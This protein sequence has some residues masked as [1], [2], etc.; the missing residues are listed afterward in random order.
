MINSNRK[1]KTLLTVLSIIYLYFYLVF[2]LF[3]SHSLLEHNSLGN[4]KYHSHLENELHEHETEE[5]ED[6]HSI[7]DFSN[8]QQHFIKI[9]SVGLNST[10]KI[11]NYI[12]AVL[13]IS[14]NSSDSA[15]DNSILV[16][17]NS[18]GTK[19]QREKCVRFAANVSP[20][21]A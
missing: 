11:F 12:S 18:P 3:H 17:K 4:E 21:L 2:P 9:N 20:P 19:I 13:I 5:H 10:Q 1:Y 6:H 7:D 8:H 16:V 15:I 14:Y